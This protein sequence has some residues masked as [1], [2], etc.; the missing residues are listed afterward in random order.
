MIVRQSSFGDVFLVIE[1]IMPF[2]ES[3]MP[4]LRLPARAVFS[5][6]TSRRWSLINLIKD[7]Y[8]VNVT[9]MMRESCLHPQRSLLIGIR[10]SE[11]MI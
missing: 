3:A 4:S 9:F 8:T 7:D 11:R 5:H 2:K 1:V 10:T 6:V